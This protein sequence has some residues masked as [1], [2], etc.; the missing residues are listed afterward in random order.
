M[1]K[2]RSANHIKK[3]RGNEARI[4]H[5]AGLGGDIGCLYHATSQESRAGKK[6]ERSDENNEASFKQLFFDA[7]PLSM[8]QQNNILKV[9]NVA[10]DDAMHKSATNEDII[11]ILDSKK[12]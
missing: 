1:P 12:L 6:W 10:T 7:K 8:S 3:G 2:S 9:S 4:L 11:L 5:S